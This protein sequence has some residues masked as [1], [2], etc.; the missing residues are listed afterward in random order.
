[1]TID[2]TQVLTVIA[3]GISQLVL[4]SK[5]FLVQA[6]RVLSSKMSG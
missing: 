1:M 4:V 6:Q 5:E 2:I 3:A